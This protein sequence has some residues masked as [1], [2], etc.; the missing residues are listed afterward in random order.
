MIR[1]A[2]VSDVSAM[3]E[4]YNQAIEDRVFSNCDD[5]HG[6]SDEFKS[7]YFSKN[8]RCI[9]LVSESDTK[10]NIVG[11]SAIKKF[12]ARPYDTLIA[13]V[14]VYIRRENRSAG[15]GIRLLRELIKYAKK[16]GLQSLVAIILGRNLQ[17]LRGCKSCGFEE[18]VRMQSIANI[19]GEEDDIIWMQKTLT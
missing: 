11:W 14:A 9:V 4:V 13:E 6:S 18:K 15:T 19:Y 7:L 8:N 16:C 10:G 1:L 2:N 12:S 3:V 17:S 5:L